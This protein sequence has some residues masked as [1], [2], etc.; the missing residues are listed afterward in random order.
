MHVR[1]LLVRAWMILRIRI[2]LRAMG[3][4]TRVER[5]TV[6][7]V[8]ARI[9]YLR[10]KTKEASSAKTFDFEKRL[11]EVREREDALR[12]EK[13]AAKKALRERARVDLA[14]DVTVPETQEQ[15]DMMQMMG[16]GGFGTSKK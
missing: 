1:L 9:A 7:Q 6:E 12:A 15:N 13:K 4:T 8:R 10:E 14:K 5:S 3:Q 16:F 2:D 11:A